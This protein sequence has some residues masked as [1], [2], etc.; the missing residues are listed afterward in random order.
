MKLENKAR[1]AQGFRLGFIFIYW[2]KK[3]LLSGRPEIPKISTMGLKP[4]KKELKI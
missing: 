3:N 4:S 1:L 2:R